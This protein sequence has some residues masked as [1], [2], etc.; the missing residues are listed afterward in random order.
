MDDTI[1]CCFRPTTLAAMIADMATQVEEGTMSEGMIKD[2]N[3]QAERL[4]GEL[5]GCVGFVGA[6]N[7]IR[8][9]E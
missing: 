6:I 9:V 5:V 8:D 1:V 4:F 2:V 3:E 7:M